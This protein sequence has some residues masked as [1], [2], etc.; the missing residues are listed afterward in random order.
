[1]RGNLTDFLDGLLNKSNSSRPSERFN[2]TRIYT[3]L[4][5]SPLKNLTQICPIEGTGVVVCLHSAWMHIDCA[6]D[7]RSQA[8]WANITF[9]LS[10][11]HSYSLFVNLTAMPRYIRSS[12]SSNRTSVVMMPNDAGRKWIESVTDG[13]ATTYVVDYHSNSTLLLEDKFSLTIYLPAHL[14]A[15]ATGLLVNGC[16]AKQALALSI[17]G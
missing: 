4:G 16:Q 11:D 15:N 10:V 13:L 1:M 8:A 17:G 2:L 5:A 7:E 9:V 3:N 6:A 12:S 14:Y